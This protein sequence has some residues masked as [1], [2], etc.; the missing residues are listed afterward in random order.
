VTEISSTAA[1]TATEMPTMQ[2]VLDAIV[3]ERGGRAAFNASQYVA[4]RA[5]VRLLAACA[6]GDVSKVSGVAVLERMLPPLPSKPAQASDL[7]SYLDE[8]A[9]RPPPSSA[10]DISVP[11][12]PVPGR[13]HEAAA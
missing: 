11:E 13:A 7:R 6:N 1:G 12:D 2:D 10:D 3:A 5:L 8:L 4:A 9:Q